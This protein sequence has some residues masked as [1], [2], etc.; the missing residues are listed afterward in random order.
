[1]FHIERFVVNPF[2]ENTFVVHDESCEAV[3]IDCGALFKEERNA[4]LDYIHNNKLTVKHLLDTHAH[5]D[6]CFGNNTIAE[7]FGIYPEVCIDDKP[8]MDCLAKQSEEYC[9]YSLNYDM[10]AVNNYLKD[11]DIIS[12]GSHS[13]S[14][15]QTPGHTPGSVLFY[16]EAEKVAFSGDT[17][18]RMSVGRTDLELGNYKTLKASLAKIASILPHD[19]TILPG[20]GPQ[21]I[22]KDEILMNPYYTF[23]DI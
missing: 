20:H 15:I 22:L 5:I 8:L 6:H 7:E 17:L 23:R 11:G 1:M 2:Q 9:N 3:I 14:V 10:P 13:L 4:V 21:T 18:F 12:F 16:F 19:T